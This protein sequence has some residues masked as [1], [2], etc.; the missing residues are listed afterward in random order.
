M[1]LNFNLE[2]KFGLDYTNGVVIGDIYMI[3]TL[4]NYNTGKQQ[5]PT[6]LGAHDQEL[7]DQAKE[8]F[9]NNGGKSL[10]P[11]GLELRIRS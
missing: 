1:I 3:A 2:S 6:F 4:H 7:I 8:W 11:N 10:Y 9:L 5:G